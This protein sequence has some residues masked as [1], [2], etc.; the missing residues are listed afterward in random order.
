MKTIASSGDSN[1]K[2]RDEMKREREKQNERHPDTFMSKTG[3]NFF[4][5]NVFMWFCVWRVARFVLLISYYCGLVL[6]SLFPSLSYL[7]KKRTITARYQNTFLHS[8]SVVRVYFDAI[9]KCRAQFFFDG[10]LSVCSLTTARHDST[11]FCVKLRSLFFF[12]HSCV[13]RA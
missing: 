5:F 6:K 7:V 3:R 1:E 10:I 13:Q 4:Y 2:R 9:R 12:L 11:V 8:S